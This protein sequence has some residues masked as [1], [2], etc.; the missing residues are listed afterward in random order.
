MRGAR[1][2]EREKAKMDEEGMEMDTEG[3]RTWITVNKTEW[4]GK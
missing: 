1:K 2:R 3:S 4:K